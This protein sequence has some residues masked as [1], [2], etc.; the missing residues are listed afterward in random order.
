MAIHPTTLL[1][2]DDPRELK[3]SSPSAARQVWSAHDMTKARFLEIKLYRNEQKRISLDRTVGELEN[4]A[5][6]KSN[7][8]KRFPEQQAGAARVLH[9]ET[10]H[11]S[12][13]GRHK[14]QRKQRSVS[15]WSP[16][17]H[18][19]PQAERAIQSGRLLTRGLSALRRG[20][21]GT[22][23]GRDGANCFC[24]WFPG[25]GLQTATACSRITYGSSGNNA[26]HPA[27]ARTRVCMGSS[28]PPATTTTMRRVPPHTLFIYWAVVSSQQTYGGTIIN[29][30]LQGKK[31]RIKDVNLLAQGHAA[32]RERSHGG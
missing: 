26:S 21:E 2:G 19:R 28:T 11:T 5:G 1:R 24:K 4:L 32:G 12:E 13:R 31:L 6:S 17:Q 7:V 29:P 22:V 18:W 3:R 30:T 9:G 20:L 8:L 10:F 27:S 25:P 15:P 14:K 16:G 23:K